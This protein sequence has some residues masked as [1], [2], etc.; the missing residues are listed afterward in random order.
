MAE[1]QPTPAR[2]ISPV[3]EPEDGYTL[4]SSQATALIAQHP[5]PVP[6]AQMV[7]V[8]DPALTKISEPEENTSTEEVDMTYVNEIRNAKLTA[9]EGLQH[10]KSVAS[11]TTSGA[12]GTLVS[13]LNKKRKGEF[14]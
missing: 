7:S 6:T 10:M 11:V 8:I 14:L 9:E 12:A 2:S 1:Q 3:F 4:D 13:S 5:L